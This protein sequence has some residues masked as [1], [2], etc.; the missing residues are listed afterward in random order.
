MRKLAGR[1]VLSVALAC[2]LV[3]SAAWAQPAQ[4][5]QTAVQEAEA[6]VSTGVDIPEDAVY[7][8]DAIIVVYEDADGGDAAAQQAAEQ[9]TEELDEAGLAVEE[10]LVEADADTAATVLATVPGGADVEEAIAAAEDVEGVAYA[11]PNYVYELV[12]D[13]WE[14]EEL[15]AE[16]CAEPEA[17]EAA[18]AT[19]DSAL[20]TAAVPSDPAAAVSKASTYANQYYLYGDLLDTVG[21]KGANIID[22][23]DDV[24]CDNEVTVVVMDTGV[25]LQHVDLQANLLAEYCYDFCNDEALEADGDFCGDYYGH[26]TH[27]AGIVA[28]TADNGTGIAGTS[29]NANIIAYK[30]TDDD[31]GSPLAS[32]AWVVSAY[33]QMF[34]LVEEQPDL[35]IHVVNIS[36]GSYSEMTSES[37][38]AM[39]ECICE[40]REAGIITVCAGG[41]GN[42]GKPYTVSNYPADWEECLAVTALSTDGTNVTWSDF[43][44]EKDIS[45]PGYLVY[46]T[47]NEGTDSYTRMSG[48]SMAAP[49]VSGTFAL[50]WAACP[51]ATVDEVVQAVQA[52]ADEVDDSSDAYSRNSTGYNGVVSGS[53]GAL[54]AAAAVEY[55]LACSQGEHTGGTA[56]C[57]SPAVCEVCGAEYGEVDAD[58]HSWGTEATWEW[59]GDY[60]SATATLTCEYDATHT[61]S[62]TA[63]TDAGITYEVTAAPTATE[64]GTGTYTATVELEG[65][66]YTSTQTV[67]IAA[68]GE[69]SSDDDANGD[70]DASDDDTSDDDASGDTGSGD[71]ASDDDA[72]GDDTSDDDS[73]S[74]GDADS[75]DDASS[76]DASSGGDTS[77]D[78]TSDDASGDDDTSGDSSSGDGASSGD[79]A[80]SDD[81]DS[82]DDASSDDA[83]SGGDTSGDGTSSDDS[84]SGDD[85]SGDDASS[86]DDAADTSGGASSGSDATNAGSSGGGSSTSGGG[87]SSG[88]TAKKANTAKIAAKKTVKVKASKLK[89]KARLRKA[90]TVKKAKGAVTYKKVSGSKRLSVTKKGKVKVKKN[91]KKGTYKIR[92]KVT[93]KGTAKYKQ[94][95]KAFTVKV[96]V[97]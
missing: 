33:E 63:T 62:A 2:L 21:I 71:D 76:D 86:G 38:L 57:T 39:H 22:A 66:T 81:A 91:T 80:D 43:N 9:T 49:V 40:A 61:T 54:N 29:Y 8:D 88:S 74:G 11:Q 53:A 32:T 16:E 75:D 84:S 46:S 48:T 17:E 68:T 65:A 90:I 55:L 41:N 14:A 77:G 56:T 85:A 58:A 37:D 59:A 47:Y 35:N 25:N 31:T 42:G 69:D 97:T 89:K 96:K 34:E 93:V 44:E 45:A 94:K 1:L 6:S 5:A 60:S 36:L 87:A 52:T 12:D 82:D 64:E 24:Q 4:A 67:A 15:S 18:E 30:I 28:A 50:L 73:S 23:W 20:D 83:S 72:S 13:G 26:G 7:E 3:P 92:I 95:V 10:V 19:S 27:V 79:D 78:G 70:D 51:D